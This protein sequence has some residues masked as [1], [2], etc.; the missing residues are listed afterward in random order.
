MNDKMSFKPSKHM[1]YR[2]VVKTP[3]VAFEQRFQTKGKP[4]FAKRDFG[5]TQPEIW[6]DDRH[7]GNS[8]YKPPLT[9]E[10]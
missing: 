4:S 8:G 6:N 10:S 3:I 7:W 2:Y 9:P 5:V 1:A